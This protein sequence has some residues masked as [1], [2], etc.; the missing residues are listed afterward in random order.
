[1]DRLESFD[2]EVCGAA[3][4]DD[5]SSDKVRRFVIIAREARGLSLSEDAPMSQ[6]LEELGLLRQGLPTNAAVLLFGLSPQGPFPSARIE[7]THLEEGRENK[8]LV[9]GGTVFEAI[10]QAMYFVLSRI[11]LPAEVVREGV[12]NAVA[13]RDYEEPGRIEIR[14]F[15][16]RLEVRNPG[17][18][19][20]ALSLEKLRQ[21]HSSVPGNP[22]LAEALYLATYRA[23]KGAGT[24]GM[25]AGC[26]Q[27]GLPEPEFQQA[28]G[29]AVTLRLKPALDP[30]PG[31]EAAG[32]P[33]APPA[34]SQLSPQLLALVSLLGQAGALGNAEMLERLGLKDRVNLHKH[35]LKPALAAG[36][37]EPT[38]PDKPNSPLQKYRLTA[39]GRALLPSRL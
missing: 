7:C 28:G 19:P 12:V 11:R 6:A 3:A 18:L 22:L 37:I 24:D 31:D 20:P 32:S 39:K 27:A 15:Q 1:M 8:P 36:L 2:S 21:P 16:D 35:Y 10:D 14:V 4:L 23:S 26:R 30:S 17:A 34:A 9:C 5:L 25:V 38:I 29:F 33:A 13:H